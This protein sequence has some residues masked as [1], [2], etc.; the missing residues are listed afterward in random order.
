MKINNEMKVATEIGI[1]YYPSHTL[2][3]L[4]TTY[5]PINQTLSIS[6]LHMKLNLL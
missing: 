3:L 5:L 2:Y 1:T 4:A 6:L